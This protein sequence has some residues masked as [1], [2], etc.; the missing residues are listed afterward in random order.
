MTPAVAKALQ[1]YRDVAAGVRKP[2][3]S[4]A[5]LEELTNVFEAYEEGKAEGSRVL[6]VGCNRVVAAAREDERRSIV[7]WLR[8]GGGPAD[9]GEPAGWPTIRDRDLADALERRIDQEKRPR[10]PRPDAEYKGLYG[11]AEHAAIAHDC[12]DELVAAKE[13]IA[14][15]EAWIARSE[16][17]RI[18]YQARAA[19]LG[20]SLWRYGDH[21]GACPQPESSC[22]CGFAKA[23][24]DATAEEERCA[25]CG[26]IVPDAVAY[27]DVACMA[28]ADKAGSR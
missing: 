6:T 10:R 26:K 15:L 2:D 27:C 7:A 1:R 8:E 4:P 13:H 22:N 28:A 12:C 21:E 18:M 3:A 24:D 25:S 11:T 23:G 17:A 19:S 20:R 16:A 14:R 9:D 5:E